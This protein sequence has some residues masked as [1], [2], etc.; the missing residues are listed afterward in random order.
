MIAD[1]PERPGLEIRMDLP[2]G[3]LAHVN[4]YTYTH[5]GTTYIY[6]IF[7]YGTVY[8][9]FC[10]SRTRRSEGGDD[11]DENGVAIMTMLMMSMMIMMTT[12]NIR[13]LRS[14]TC[15]RAGRLL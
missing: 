7:V 2:R 13:V 5:M 9:H 6:L 3:R 4:T 14:S 15:V 1:V 8:I 10:P 12:A 11:D